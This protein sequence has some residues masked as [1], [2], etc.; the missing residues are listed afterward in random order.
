MTPVP[1]T[2]MHK[3]PS[4]ERFAP[5]LQTVCL[6]SLYLWLQSYSR[7]FYI[8]S[9]IDDLCYVTLPS[10][11][12]NAEEDKSRSMIYRFNR[13]TMYTDFLVR[14]PSRK[15]K[16]IQ[17]NIKQRCN[18]DATLRSCMYVGHLGLEPTMKVPFNLLQMWTLTTSTHS[19]CPVHQ[20]TIWFSMFPAMICCVFMQTTAATCVKLTLRSS[21]SGPRSIP[22]QGFH[23]NAC[24][25]FTEFLANLHCLTAGDFV[26]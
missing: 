19:D 26:R 15:G 5:S 7:P 13:S 24:G 22:W 6:L 21:F 18:I 8:Y 11:S 12:R 10:T 25:L 3:M 1:Q 2:V 17:K 23:S 9:L 16:N 14:I 4:A 20:S